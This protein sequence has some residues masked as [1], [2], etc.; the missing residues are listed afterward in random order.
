MDGVLVDVLPCL[1]WEMVYLF[2]YGWFVLCS[3][4]V[5]RII[6]KEILS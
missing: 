1:Q 6:Y 5:A 4:A 3:K 2:G